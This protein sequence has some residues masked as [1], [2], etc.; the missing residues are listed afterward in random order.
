LSIYGSHLHASISDSTGVSI[1]GHLL[2]ENIVYTTV[3]IIMGESKQ[4][5][6]TR[7]KDGTT[8]WNE[9]QIKHIE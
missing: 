2:E 7:E 6:F 3:E 1:G 9:L 8:P 5:Q 4:L